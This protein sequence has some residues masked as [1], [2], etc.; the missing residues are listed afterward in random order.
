MRL[1]ARLV[2]IATVLITLSPT[3]AKAKRIVVP[4]VYVFG[5]SA[6]FTD[7][8]V[9]FT[10]IQ[11]LDSAWVEKKTGFL[12][13]RDQYSYQLR[14]YLSTKLQQPHRTCIVFYS[15]KLEKLQK[16]LQKVR[17]LYAHPKEGAQHFDVRQIGAADF[18][19]MVI[20]LS[21]EIAMEEQQEVEAKAF[22]KEQ[23]K[24]A[25]QNKKKKKKKG[26]EEE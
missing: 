24:Q 15:Q 9:Y 26:G 18:K 12:Q 20:D 23:K 4:H 22:L 19:F 16:K 13:D 14:D 2:C 11:T 1:F 6:S 8:L 5:L 17:R 21:E 25:K 3:T 10:D 7:S